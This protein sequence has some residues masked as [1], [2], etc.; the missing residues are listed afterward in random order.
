MI[1]SIDI[2]IDTHYIDE[3]VSMI[4]TDTFRTI[5]NNPTGDFFYDPWDIKEEFKN[6][7]WEKL[8][9]SL[10]QPIGEARII[11][12]KPGSCYHSHTD[13]DDRYH[14][15][16]Q[17]Q[18]SY[19]IDVDNTKMYETKTDGVW[20]IMNTSRRHVA[21][22]FG[23]IDRIQLVVRTLLKKNT[24][25]NPIKVKINP[26]IVDIDKARFLFDDKVSNWLNKANKN[27]IIS[28]FSTDLKTVSF[29]V[30]QSYL[31]ELGTILPKEFSIDVIAV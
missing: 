12:L 11:V 4:H 27:N 26:K 18:Y 3:A 25:V 30:E 22:N 29:T 24:L 9:S 16:L 31:E 10:P 2:T 15:N 8:L 5:I 20:H 14:L 6:T 23:S 13:I 19:L 7:I 21:A 28:N 17:G 1:K